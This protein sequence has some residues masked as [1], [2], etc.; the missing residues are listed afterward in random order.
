MKNSKATRDA[1]EALPEGK[2]PADCAGCR[3]CEAVCPQ[4]IRIADIMSYFRG[5]LSQPI[6][7]E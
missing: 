7:E 2:R 1:V 5:I 4:Q 6:T 3:S